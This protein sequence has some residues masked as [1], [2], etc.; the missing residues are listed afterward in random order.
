MTPVTESVDRLKVG[1]DARC[2]ISLPESCLLVFAC[3]ELQCIESVLSG[4]GCSPAKTSIEFLRVSQR[5]AL[6]VEPG[7]DRDVAAAAAGEYGFLEAKLNVK[8]RACC[9]SMFSMP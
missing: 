5:I 1:H 8:K 7:R 6:L 9:S 3:I 2:R 4:R